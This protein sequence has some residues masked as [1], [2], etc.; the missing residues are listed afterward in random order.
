MGYRCPGCGKDFGFD[1]KAFDNHL[2]F[3]CGEGAALAF[4]ALARIKTMCGKD[5]L[6]D[7]DIKS[8]NRKSKS[9]SQISPNHHW[10]KQ[11]VVSD[12]EGYD[13]VVCSLCG[14]KA[15]RILGSFKFDMRQSMSKIENC[16][17][18]KKK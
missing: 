14:I 18:N 8:E 1:K 4:A 5:R 3:K 13:I 16:I 6:S 15:K 7:K 10:V 2:K 17:N 12:K 11:N 9:Y